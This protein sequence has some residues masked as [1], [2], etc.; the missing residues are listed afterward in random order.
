MENQ[1]EQN[2]KEKSFN[3]SMKEIYINWLP[4]VAVIGFFALIVPNFALAQ[5]KEGLVESISEMGIAEEAEELESFDQTALEEQ[6]KKEVATMER[7]AQKM[8]S[9]IQALR[10]KNTAH[11]AKIDKLHVQFKEGSKKTRQLKTEVSGLDRQQSRLKANVDK[12]KGKVDSQAEE[13]RSMKTQQRQL[14]KEIRQLEREK[15]TLKK[16]SKQ[17]SLRISESK[18]QIK[19]LEKQRNSLQARR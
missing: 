18:R 7:E 3:K 8:E 2:L 10:G 12:I 4:S 16:R 11:Q 9:R 13:I 19:K 5:E 15:E 17:Q 1:K 14:A 6:T